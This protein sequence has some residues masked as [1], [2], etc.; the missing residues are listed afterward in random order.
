MGKYHTAIMKSLYARKPRVSP[1][2]STEPTR[3]QSRDNGTT[4]R[5]HGTQR[6]DKNQKQT[7]PVAQ[8]DA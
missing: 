3:S 1:A 6:T 5:H 7:D 8:H 4:V 2:D